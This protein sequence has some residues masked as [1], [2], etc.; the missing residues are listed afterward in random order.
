LKKDIGGTLEDW[1]SPERY[2]FIT[3]TR[4]AVVCATLKEDV[5]ELSGEADFNIRAQKAR[6]VPQPV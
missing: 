6:S 5:V 1:N 4:W 2:N 3:D